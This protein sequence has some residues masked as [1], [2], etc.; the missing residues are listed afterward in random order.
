MGFLTLTANK[1]ISVLSVNICSY[2]KS[3]APQKKLLTKIPVAWGGALRQDI[4]IFMLSAH[5]REKTTHNSI[6]FVKYALVG[7]KKKKQTQKS[8]TRWRTESDKGASWAGLTGQQPHPKGTPPSTLDG[9]LLLPA[10][11]LTRGSHSMSRGNRNW[12]LGFVQYTSSF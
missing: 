1:D 2:Q 9:L 6:I 7:K 10:M 8:C 4:I 11:R 5:S 3:L 12:L